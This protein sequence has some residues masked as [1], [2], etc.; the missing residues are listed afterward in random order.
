MKRNSLIAG[1]LCAVL[2]PMA[3]LGA[4]RIDGPIEA[5][6]V[7]VIDGDTLVVV[8]EVWPGVEVE[9]KVRLLGIDTPEIRRAACAA[10]RQKGLRARGYV[11]AAMARG[12]VAL[13]DIRHGKYAGRV[14]ARVETEKGDLG[15][16]LLRAGLAQPYKGKKSW[17]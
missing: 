14:L 15:R 1:L 7:R 4:A 8:A 11:S 13:T 16:G 9:T 3:A 17:C 10:E 5:R 12:P 6:L 2:W